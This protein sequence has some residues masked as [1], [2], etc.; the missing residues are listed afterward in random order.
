MYFKLNNISYKDNIYIII[1]LSLFL[2]NLLIRVNL[3]L[4]GISYL[5]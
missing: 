2:K 5:L 3:M 4:E 1:D